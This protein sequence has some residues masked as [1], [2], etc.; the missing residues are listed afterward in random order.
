VHISM[1]KN[2]CVL[3]VLYKQSLPI[4]NY[5]Y[6]L[7]RIII[8]IIIKNWKILLCDS[9]PGQHLCNN[10]LRRTVTCG[11]IS[12]RMTSDVTMTSDHISATTTYVIWREEHLWN[13]CVLQRVHPSNLLF[14][15]RFFSLNILRLF[16]LD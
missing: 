14:Y 10:N 2:R 12:A 13:T 1:K 5:N 3:T 7:I 15:S 11:N 6:K 16:N 8:I 9:G 4:F